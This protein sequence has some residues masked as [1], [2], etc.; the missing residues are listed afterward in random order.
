M[1]KKFILE[2]LVKLAQG[3]G[4][5]PTKFMGTK[6]NISFLGKGPTSN[7]LFQSPVR[8]KHYL[9]RGR[10]EESVLGEINDAMGFAT[11]G[12]LNPIQLEILNDNLIKIAT[13][14]KPSALPSLPSASVTNIAPG[15]EGLKGTA[16]KN[17]PFTGWTPYVVPKF[18][19][20]GL[21]EILQAPRSGMRMGG[22]GLLTRG[23]RNAFKRTQHGYDSPY[24]DMISLTDDASYLMSPPNMQK[25]K[26]LEIYRTQLVRDILRKEGRVGKKFNPEIPGVLKIDSR[27]PKPE[28]TRADL[29]LLDDYIAQLKKKIQEVGYYGEGAAKE[30]ALV[31]SRPDLPFPKFVRDKFKHAEGG[32]A[33]ILEV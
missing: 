24:S 4:A 32:L 3:I 1:G 33:R 17:R 23:I 15:I 12:K 7:I 18:A 9:H 20:G 21:A 8:I 30:K 19:S 22:L 10:S 14:M 6:T 11:A 25:I 5:N 27:N 13:I 29:Q 28:A 31:A 2:N 16:K 26:K